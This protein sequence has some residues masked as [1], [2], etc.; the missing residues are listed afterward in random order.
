MPVSWPEELTLTIDSPSM[1]DNDAG[2]QVQTV[3]V[4]RPGLVN[5]VEL[6]PNWTLSGTNTNTRTY[7]LLNLGQSG[8]GS[9]TVATLALTSGVNL[10]R[11]VS[12]AITLGAGADRI[13]A[14]GDVL[15]WRSVA[16]GN[17]LPDVG[18]QVVIQ[19]SFT[20]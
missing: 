6:I 3:R 7:T 16:S 10:A 8:A 4:I 11:G 5:S 15:A 9:A 19:Q 13:V 2:D 1:F 12:K 17:G 20:P 18:G 14:A